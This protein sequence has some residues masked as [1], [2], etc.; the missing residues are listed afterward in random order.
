MTSRPKF[1][2]AETAGAEALPNGPGTIRKSSLS[3]SNRALRA[4]WGIVQLILF[5]PSPV[6][7][8]AWRRLLLRLFGARIGQ[9]CLIYPSARIWAPWNLTMA[10]FS[11]IGPKVDCYTVDSVAIGA[12]ASVSQ[13]SF[14]CTA[15]HDVD[16]ATLA[17]VTAPITVEPFAW[18][19]ADCFIGPGVRI[20]EG[21]V[22]G[23]RSTAFRDIPPWH[24]VA[25]QP[26]RFIRKRSHAV[27][28]A[29]TNTAASTGI[30]S[31][32][33][34]TGGCRPLVPPGHDSSED[35]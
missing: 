35:A 15:G 34:C 27:K 33:R 17:L 7:L 13:Y 1:R 4:L 25:G 8:H 3:V 23:A 29:C 14:L 11:C 16:S 18:V 32:R 28:E 2:R 21:A 22:V 5:I 20:G 30:R 19:A 6:P 10:E 24:I 31:F 9:G 26:P 12:Y